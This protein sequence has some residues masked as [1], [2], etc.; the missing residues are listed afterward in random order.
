MGHRSMVGVSRIGQS[1]DTLAPWSLLSTANP[2]E[3]HHL[4]HLCPL[5]RHTQRD[6][7]YPGAPGPTLQSLALAKPRLPPPPTHISLQAYHTGGTPPFILLPQARAGGQAPLGQ[8]G[9][10]RASEAQEQPRSP[11]HVEAGGLLC[12]HLHRPLQGRLQPLRTDLGLQEASG[13]S[14][15]F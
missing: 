13:G 6:C 10:R 5:Q 8:Y 15:F 14:G 9:H 7:L 2:A 4:S 11:T 3:G 12:P 1:G